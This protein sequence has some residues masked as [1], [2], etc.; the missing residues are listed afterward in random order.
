[1]GSHEKEQLIYVVLGRNEMVYLITVGR[2]VRLQGHRK[3][4]LA[5]MFTEQITAGL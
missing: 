1:M 4:Q 5:F 3:I 2:R